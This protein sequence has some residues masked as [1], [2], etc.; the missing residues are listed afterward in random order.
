M[1]RLGFPIRLNVARVVVL[2][3]AIV[4]LA[5]SVMQAQE[6]VRLRVGLRGDPQVW[7]E[8][9]IPKFHAQHPDIII[10]HVEGVDWSLDKI[11]LAEVAGQPYDVIYSVIETAWAIAERGLIMPLD[12]FLEDDPWAD[13]F[14]YDVHPTLLE[15]WRKDGRQYY[16]PFEWNNVVMYYNPRLFNEAGLELPH[17][18]WTWDEFLTA[19]RAITVHNPDG[20]TAV[21]GYACQMSNPWGFGPWILSAGGQILNDTWTESALNDPRVVDAFEFVRSLIFEHRAAKVACDPIPETGLVGMWPG[22]RNTLYWY[23]HVNTDF[24]DYDIQFWPQ[25]ERRATTLG[26]GGYSIS[27]S[28]PNKEA[29]WTFIKWLN[30]PEVVE[31]WALLGASPSRTSVAMSDV[32]LSMPPDNHI[33]YFEALNHSFVVP[34]PVNYPEIDQIFNEAVHRVWSGEMSPEAALL[35]AHRLINAALRE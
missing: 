7:I 31:Y 28:S 26:G 23:V 4:L 34:T 35:E 25:K 17:N 10:E 15:M 22:G 32:I 13:D 30:S 6:P 14:L 27:A 29:A 18:D 8:E 16:L 20:T 1:I 24:V 11:I 33:L 9:L 12:S 19:A 2:V 21:D 5:S 3:A